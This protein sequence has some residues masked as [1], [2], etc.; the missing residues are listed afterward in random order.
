MIKGQPPPPPQ[1][2]SFKNNNLRVFGLK[3]Y[4]VSFKANLDNLET[5][6]VQQLQKLNP[7]FKITDEIDIYYQL[8]SLYPQNNFDETS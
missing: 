4:D 1:T 7:N 3:Y 5:K 6:A 8:A 2:Q